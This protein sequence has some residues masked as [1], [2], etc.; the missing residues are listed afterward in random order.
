MRKLQI[1]L[2]PIELEAGSERVSEIPEST[3]SLMLLD[4]SCGI[5]SFRVFHYLSY[6]CRCGFKD[7]AC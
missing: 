3:F 4:P 7:R 1:P 6:H 2:R 5:A